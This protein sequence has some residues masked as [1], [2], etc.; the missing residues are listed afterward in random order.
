[1]AFGHGHPLVSINCNRKVCDHIVGLLNACASIFALEVD[2]CSHEQ[3]IHSGWD[4]TAYVDSSLFDMYSKCG[5]LREYFESVKQDGIWRCG[6]LECHDW[7]ICN[8]GEDTWMYFAKC[9]RK[10]YNQPLFALQGFGMHVS[11]W[12]LLK[13]AGM[14][15]SRPFEVDGIHMSLWGNSLV[16][17]YAKCGSFEDASRGFNKMPDLVRWSLGMLC[18]ENVL[19]MAEL[20]KPL[21]ILIACMKKV[22]SQMMSLFFCL[23]SACSCAGSADEAMSCYTPMIRV[24]MGSPKLE[25]YIC[26]VDSFCCAGHLQE[27]ENMMC[28]QCPVNQMYLLHGGL[29]LGI[30][31]SMQVMWRCHLLSQMFFMLSLTISHF[32]Y[33]PG[34]NTNSC[35]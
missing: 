9:N 7:D 13:K 1:M 10:V 5:S 33:I 23:L 11:M 31:E 6:H 22:Y 8:V 28:R 14:H 35:S 4:S 17:M 12:L 30:V 20:K 34:L 32:S 19:C 27:A 15:M 2:R 25:H 3:I 21:N 26:M 29:R 18:M 24:Y 16:G